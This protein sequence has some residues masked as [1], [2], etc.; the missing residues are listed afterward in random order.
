MTRSTRDSLLL[1]LTN[2]CGS[3]T[4]VSRVYVLYERQS[5]L[6]VRHRIHD[7]AQEGDEATVTK[8]ARRRL[9]FSPCRFQALGVSMIGTAFVV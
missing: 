6:D 4:T 9:L 3:K 2:P 8:G 5:G 1:H 7:Y